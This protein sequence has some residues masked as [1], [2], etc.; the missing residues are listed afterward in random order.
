MA[1]RARRGGSLGAAAGLAITSVL[2]FV[3][4][5]AA[6]VVAGDEAPLEQLTQPG[7]LQD[8]PFQMRGGVA[9]TLLELT[10]GSEQA[11]VNAGMDPEE[12]LEE[13]RH[14]DAMFIS[15]DLMVGYAEPVRP[16]APPTPPETRAMA[17]ASAPSLSDVFDLNSRP[18]ST[19]VLFID[20]DGHT[21]TD[22]FWNSSGGIDSIVSAPYNQSGPP[23]TFTDQERSSMHEI[24]E[25][26]AADFAP[27]DINV[28]TK[29]PGVSG[30]ARS[31][32]SDTAFGTRVVVTSSDWFRDAHGFYVAGVA[33][34]DVW[35]FG[36]DLPAFSFSSNGSDGDPTYTAD[37]IVHE[38]G[39]VLGLEHDGTRRGNT[40]EEYYLGHNGWA[41]IMGSGFDAV[42]AQWSNGTYS[43]A[44]NQ[45]DDV[46]L[47]IAELGAVADSDTSRG[48][49]T[50]AATSQHTGVLTS[51]TD[52][53][54]YR[55]YVGAGALRAVV[56]AGPYSDAFASVTVRNA[57]GTVVASATSPTLEGWQAA[58]SFTAQAGFYFIEVRPAAWRTPT[59][60]FTAYGSVGSYALSVNGVNGGTAPEEPP[61]PGG[62]TPTDDEEP[63]ESIVGSRF[64]AVNPARIVDTRATA[65]G[66]PA[67]GGALRLRGGDQTFKVPVAGRG[68]VP[69]SAS[70]AVLNVVAVNPSDA[71]FLTVHPCERGT[72]KSSTLNYDAG[73]T[74]A[75]TTIAT[76][77]G[78]GSVCVYSH[79]SVD[80][81]IDVTGWLGD[82]GA[83]K[84]TPVGPERALDTRST[85]GSTRFIADT[86]RHLDLSNIVPPGTSAVA[87]NVTAV[88]PSGPG[89]L[90][91]YPCGSKRPE[92]SSVNFE[93]GQI[94]PNNAIVGIN[95]SSICIYSRTATD[96]VVD[97]TGAFGADG[98]SY[99]PA[100]SSRLRDTRSDAGSRR[101]S[102]VV[103]YEVDAPDVAGAQVAA[104]SVNI[105]ATNHRNQGFVTTFGCAGTERIPTAST[106]NPEPGITSANGAIVPVD[107]NRTSCLFTSG[108]GDL[109]ADLT[110]WWVE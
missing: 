101:P 26:V 107:G 5:P 58:V 73:A 99:L 97:I 110:G 2:L 27:F 34:L 82:D 106:L 15:S 14:D 13:L 30:L 81:I 88:N 44:S 90:T 86:A 6:Q 49:T 80:V 38:F 21:T 100:S 66:R 43:D 10:G 74:V 72:P 103:I 22:T 7:P 29:D 45:E 84:L 11:A 53:D 92:T 37:T 77:T 69:A 47:I 41:P 36:S 109:I 60:G 105:A 96:V 91:L 25:R 102:R 71:G 75:N 67:V 83:H 4:V 17:S 48:T 108:G 19:K 50:V 93:A 76:L 1:R 54:T 31:S 79:A 64:T 95:Q 87:L 16:N 98:M 42:V 3:A 24:W 63:V 52:V 78:D 39:H 33:Y 65:S 85:P 89:Y 68:G 104:A 61:T 57:A 56:S 59:T 32:A 40:H 20:F 8:E 35:G 55:V 51:E 18:S 62:D 9:A 46:S 70:A 28:T 12:L 23:E 94:R